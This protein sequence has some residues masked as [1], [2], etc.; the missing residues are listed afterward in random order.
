[1]IILKIFSKNFN[2]KKLKTMFEEYTQNLPDYS[3]LHILVKTKNLSDYRSF[4]KNE[5]DR[6]II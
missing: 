4:F 5:R 6:L 1:M 2:F 3:I